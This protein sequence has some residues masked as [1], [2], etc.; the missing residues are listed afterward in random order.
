LYATL[1]PRFNVALLGLLL[2]VLLRL[3]LNC[4]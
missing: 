2:G 1:G 3:L 4:A